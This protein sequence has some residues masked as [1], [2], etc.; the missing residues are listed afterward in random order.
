MLMI[1]ILLLIF[2]VIAVAQRIMSKIMI[3]SM[4]NSRCGDL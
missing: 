2:T 1:V 3:P 4:S